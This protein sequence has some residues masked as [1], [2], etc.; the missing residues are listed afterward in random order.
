MRRKK[1]L[2]FQ[3]FELVVRLNLNIENLKLSKLNNLKCN[4]FEMK[5]SK[6]NNFILILKMSMITNLNR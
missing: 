1:N 6:Y 5:R 4:A 3:N 2:N